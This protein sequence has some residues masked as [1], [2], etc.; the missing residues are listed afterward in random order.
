MGDGPA[1]RLTALLVRQHGTPVG[2]LQSFGLTHTFPSP[3]TLANADLDVRG[4][5]PSVAATI[6]AF[7]DAVASGAVRLDGAQPLDE[8]IQSLNATAEVDPL[9]AQYIAF[10]AGER[11]AF[12]ASKPGLQR[13]L[14]RLAGRPVT[15]AETTVLAGQWRPWRAHAAAV[16]HFASKPPLRLAAKVA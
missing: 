13:L 12:P 1:S 3:A 14:S 11:D 15:E 4:T 9:T 16:L 6:Q 10:R 8:L 7:A 2:G 5:P